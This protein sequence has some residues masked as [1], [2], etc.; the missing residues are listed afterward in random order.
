MD[1]NEDCIYTVPPKEYPGSQLAGKRKNLILDLDNTLICAFI[2]R[3]PS[4]N[5]FD[6]R[7]LYH[8]IR[9]KDELSQYYILLRP[10]LRE[11]LSLCS[12]HYNLLIFTAAEQDYA[13]P[14][15][16]LLCPQIRSERRFYRG[17]CVKINDIYIK[18]LRKLEN[19]RFNE[20]L[21]ILFD[22]HA[23]DNTV[24][25]ANGMF[26]SR[27]APDDDQDNSNEAINNLLSESASL[28]P[29]AQLFCH[30]LFLDAE[31]VRVPLRKY[32]DTL[33]QKFGLIQSGLC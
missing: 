22:D 25:Q 13:E 31:D 17:S 7:W 10:G 8:E 3:P 24:P 30:S 1:N 11:F 14:I 20:R 28:L 21:T 16:N 15:L 32:A 33:K 6:K 29:F 23:P 27:F 18:D 12:M 9:S 2:R 19:F 26:C 5:L 4:F